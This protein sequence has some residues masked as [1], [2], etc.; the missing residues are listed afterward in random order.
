MKRKKKQK[1]EEEKKKEICREPF[2]EKEVTVVYSIYNSTGMLSSQFSVVEKSYECDKNN[3]YRYLVWLSG[4]CITWKASMESHHLLFIV[5][6]IFPVNSTTNQVSA[7][8]QI[9]GVD[10]VFFNQTNALDRRNRTLKITAFNESFSSKVVINEI[11][12]YSV[13]WFLM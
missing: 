11:C 7:L 1:K 12:T 4:H 6:F 8:F 5:V 13:S 2:A 9:A 3:M 10:C